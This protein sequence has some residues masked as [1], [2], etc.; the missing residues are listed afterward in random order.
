MTTTPE[1]PV[2]AWHSHGDQ[3]PHYHPGGETA[4]THGPSA[5]PRKKRRI[6]LWVFLAI[7]VLFIAMLIYWATRSTGV[8]P[9]E[10]Q[11]TC[12]GNKWYPL[13]KSYNDCAQHSGAIAAHDV[14][15]GIAI[16]GTVIAW[17]VVDFL[18]GLTYFIYRL[19]KR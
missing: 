6:F 5:L 16:T 13:W 7:Q 3:P 11:Q 9:G 18:V 4:H 12:G 8:L 2:V 10:I 14:A 19:A 1:Q 15:K 17:V